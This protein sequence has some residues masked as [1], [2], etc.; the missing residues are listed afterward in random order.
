MWLWRLRTIRGANPRKGRRA[1][2]VIS[3][4]LTAQSIPY[5]PPLPKNTDTNDWN[6]TSGAGADYSTDRLSANQ[7]TPFLRYDPQGTG[8]PQAQTYLQEKNHFR[9][10]Q[11]LFTLG[12]PII[13]DRI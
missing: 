5:R 12:G 13:K 4:S 11:P 7:N 1:S 10:V 2:P 3:S 8:E 6:D 9:Y